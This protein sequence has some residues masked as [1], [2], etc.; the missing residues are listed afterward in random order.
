M[1]RG[2]ATAPAELGDPL[3][4]D[5]YAVLLFAGAGPVFE[6]TVPAGGTCGARP[7]WSTARGGGFRFHDRARSHGGVDRLA[8][9]PGAAGASRVSLQAKGPTLSAPAL[10]LALPTRLQVQASGGACWEAVFSATG[11]R[12]NTTTRFSGR[13]D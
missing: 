3:A 12:A 13:S 11:V 1:W 8:L 7:C 5:P 9:V 6:A 2:D 10:P 4:A